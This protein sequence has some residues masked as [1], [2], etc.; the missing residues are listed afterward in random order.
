M[1]FLFACSL[2]AV[3]PASTHPTAPAKALM[4]GGYQQVDSQAATV[5][6]ARATAQK[7]LSGIS[8]EA[9]LEAYQQV[10]AGMNYKLVCRVAGPDGAGTWEF[11]VW[12]RLDDTWKLTSARH[13]EVAPTNVQ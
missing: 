8:I 9:V 2:M 1:F 5:Q 10:V 11:V 13:L 4:P 3:T 12:H 7:A 6:E